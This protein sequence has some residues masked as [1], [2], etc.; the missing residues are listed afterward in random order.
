MG[1]MRE[2]DE[3]DNREERPSRSS[4]LTLVGLLGGAVLAAVL[5]G[6]LTAPDP[7]ARSPTA[8]AP[9]NV[10]DLP[11]TTAPNKPIGVGSLKRC[12][13]QLGGLTLGE[14]LQVPG[15]TSEIWDCDALTQGPWSLVIRAPDG[16]FG[17][18]SAVVTYPF[19]G[20]SPLPDKPVTKPQGGRWNADAQSLIWPLAGSHAQ[21]VGDVGQAQLADLAMRVTVVSGLPHLAALDGFTAAAT[22]TYRF[23]LIH[24]M[25]YET[26]DLGQESKLGTGEVWTGVTTGASFEFELLRVRAVPGGS[27]FYK[28]AGVV[29]GKPAIY[30][31]A[32]DS[33]WILAWESAPGEVAYIGYSGPVSPAD[34]VEAL[35]SLADKGKVLTPGQWET[36]DRAQVDPPSDTPP[37]IWTPEPSP[38]RP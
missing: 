36:K 17:V 38:K 34:A 16:H 11:T 14:D 15:S 13:V 6:Q 3:V 12:P 26:V 32:P 18:R 7:P 10:S 19:P 27:A 22:T 37:R 23:P 5:V 35:R 29:R 31:R 24:E 9:T 21:I 1:D 30:A 20:T 8:V 2:P 4:G 33:N 25:R 28:S